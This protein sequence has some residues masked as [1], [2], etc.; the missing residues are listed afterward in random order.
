VVPL[1][2]SASYS[3]DLAAVAALSTREA[4]RSD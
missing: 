3:V 2:L 4:N 1:G